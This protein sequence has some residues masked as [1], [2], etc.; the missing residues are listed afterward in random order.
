MCESVNQI[1]VSAAREGVGEGNLGDEVLSEVCDSD[2]KRHKVSRSQGEPRELHARLASRLAE[3]AGRPKV[4]HDSKLQLVD[5][6]TA[7]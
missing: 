6:Q 3:H 4:W 1:S 2:A 7:Q 5:R